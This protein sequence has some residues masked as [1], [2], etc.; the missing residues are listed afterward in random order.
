MPT[1]FPVNAGEYFS[2]V[3][4]FLEAGQSGM[5]VR[6]VPPTQAYLDCL[7]GALSVKQPMTEGGEAPTV[8]PNPGAECPPG[9]PVLSHYDIDWDAVYECKIQIVQE[10]PISLASGAEAEYQTF[11]FDPATLG[12]R[13]MGEEKLLPLRDADRFG[14]R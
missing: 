13:P 14:P 2:L 11:L 3:W 8:P 9:D 10:N 12:R 4:G 1:L 5:S 6:A 7:S